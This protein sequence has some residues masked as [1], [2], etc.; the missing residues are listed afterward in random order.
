MASANIFLNSS[1]SVA[2][3][4][5]VNS[6]LLS[7][8]LLSSGFSSGSAFSPS[9][10]FLSVDAFLV[11]GAFLLASSF[12]EKSK[13]IFNLP[14]RILFATSPIFCPKLS[15]GFFSFPGIG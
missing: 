9:G 8:K 10:N 7:F 4:K 14:G 6:L 12:L 13:G 15:N 5:Y 2:N 1:G 11:N 3:D